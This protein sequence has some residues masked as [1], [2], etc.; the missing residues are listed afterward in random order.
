MTPHQ[1]RNGAVML[2]LSFKRVVHGRAPIMPDENAVLNV[3][4]LAAAPVGPLPA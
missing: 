1:R 2:L 3:Q 4:R